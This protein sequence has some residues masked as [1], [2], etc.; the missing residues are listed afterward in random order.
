VGA[1]TAIGAVVLLLAAQWVPPLFAGA[2]VFAIA[3]VAG[4][5]A[6]LTPTVMATLR[7]QPPQGE[8][9]G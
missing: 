9:R 2:A 5:V 7:G 1:A 3:A 8:T 6:G 4:H